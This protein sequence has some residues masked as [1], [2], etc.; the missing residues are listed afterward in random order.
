MLLIQYVD[1]QEDLVEMGLI[2]IVKVDERPTEL[3]ATIG[4]LG[5]DGASWLQIYVRECYGTTCE[6]L[7]YSYD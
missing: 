3:L 6:R 4:C 5:M 7:L 1:I 2:S